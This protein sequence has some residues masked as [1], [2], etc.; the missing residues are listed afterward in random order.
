MSECGNIKTVRYVGDLDAKGIEIGATFAARVNEVGCYVVEPA[1][2]VHLAMLA[3]AAELSHP[4]G[5]PSSGK[6]VATDA[7]RWL[8]PESQLSISRII[9]QGRRI[10]EEV[11]HDGHYRNIWANG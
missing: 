11:L 8:S 4:D 3:A 5:W 10:P 9:S 7:E 6:Q 2:E 1:T